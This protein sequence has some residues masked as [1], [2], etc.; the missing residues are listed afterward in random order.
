MELKMPL[1]TFLSKKL[2]ANFTVLIQNDN[3]LNMSIKS[4]SLGDINIL[5][6][7]FGTI[8]LS[9]LAMLLNKAFEFGLPLFNPW[10]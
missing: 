8:D 2:F 10:L 4:L 1:S 5:S 9:L 7:T 6:T 3:Q